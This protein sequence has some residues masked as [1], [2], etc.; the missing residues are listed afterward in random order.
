[1]IT[2]TCEID[3]SYIISLADLRRRLTAISHGAHQWA[4]EIVQ[5]RLHSEKGELQSYALIGYT[6][7]AMIDMPNYLSFLFP[8]AVQPKGSREEAGTF[9][10]LHP[11]EAIAVAYGLYFEGD[12]LKRDCLE[13]WILFWLPLRE[14]LIDEPLEQFSLGI[15]TLPWR[16]LEQ[17][18]Q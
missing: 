13:D 2:Y 17:K 1:M 15:P 5:K 7:P 8:I 18:N 16:R 12:F 9:V 14:S 3:E 11:S 6:N 4:V 10:C